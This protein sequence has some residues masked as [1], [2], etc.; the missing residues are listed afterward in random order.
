MTGL[1]NV[2][3]SFD[4]AYTYYTPAPNNENDKLEV[5]ISTDCGST[6][7]TVDM[8]AGVS[9]TTAPSTTAAFVPTATQWKSKVVSLPTAANNPSVLVKFVATA[10]YG[11]NLY[12]DNVNLQ[13][14]TAL[15]KYHLDQLVQIFPNPT[16]DASNLTIHAKNDASANITVMN[17]LGQVI[18]KA[19]KNIQ[20]GF[21]Q[22]TLPSNEWQS[23]TYLININID[24]ENTVRKLNVTK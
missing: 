13:S 24:G 6:W 23:G 22:L 17:M 10:D 11:N 14:V 1:N 16:K 21:N 15:K 8:M 2:V 7:S 9:L 4:Y 19:T 3:I 20:T 18:F 5:K 12:I